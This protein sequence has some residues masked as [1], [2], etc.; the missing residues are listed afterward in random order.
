MV[1][2]DRG[3]IEAIFFSQDRRTPFLFK[4]KAGKTKT[5]VIK[6]LKTAPGNSR[7]D[8]KEV[9]FREDEDFDVDEPSFGDSTLK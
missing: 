8:S 9:T 6:V 5:L 7:D 4:W 1:N 3:L 2:K